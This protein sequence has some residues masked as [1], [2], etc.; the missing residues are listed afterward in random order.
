MRRPPSR[1]RPHRPAARPAVEG[2]ESCRLLAATLVEYPTAIPIGRLT[3][4]P[5]G[6]LWSSETDRDAQKRPVAG[7]ITA[8]DPVTHVTSKYPLPAI[9]IPWRSPTAPTAGSG[10]SR[11][12]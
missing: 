7:F 5:A 12:R 1:P 10:S 11:S 2:L 6:R 4:G 8:F 9:T 3:D